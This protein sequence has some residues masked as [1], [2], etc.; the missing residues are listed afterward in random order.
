MNTRKHIQDELNGLNSSLPADSNTFIYSVP[1]GY[2]DNLASAVLA[3]IKGEHPVTASEEISEL[4]PLL[5]GLSKAMPFS[6]PD[7][8]F[9]DLSAITDEKEESAVLSYIGKTM[10]YEVPFDYFD[11][12]S[13]EVLGKLNPS[14]AKVI[15]MYRKKW[16]KMAVAAAIVGII[17]ISGFFYFNK[18]GSISVSNPQWVATNIKNVSNTAIEE[19]IK[20]TDVTLTSTNTTTAQTKPKTAD[21]KKLLQDVP[22]TELESFLDQVP[23]DDDDLVINGL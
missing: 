8:Y 16:M 13:G 22:D 2:F 9:Q 1:E 19:F 15:P 4:S 17:A 12:L 7:N 11:N 23:T 10:P 20:T 6:I 21:I 5:A 3:K 14:T 18:K